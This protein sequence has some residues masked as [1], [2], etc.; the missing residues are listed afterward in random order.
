MPFLP[1]PCLSPS[2]AQAQFDLA[3][4]VRYKPDE[5]PSLMPHHDASTFT[6]NIA[7]NRVGVDYEVSRGHPGPGRGH[8]GGLAGGEQLTRWSRPR[9]PGY[10][11]TRKVDN[12]RERV[13]GPRGRLPGGGG[14]EALFGKREMALDTIE[15]GRRRSGA[16][17][18]GPGFCLSACSG[19]SAT[20]KT[21]KL[22]V[23]FTEF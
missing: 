14:F 13:L 16:R 6:I 23:A 8:E 18:P 9:G 4:V 3:F 7:L 22:G 15:Q 19:A 12:Q 2:L 5:Q 21:G 1:R 17:L 10:S 11:H 20:S